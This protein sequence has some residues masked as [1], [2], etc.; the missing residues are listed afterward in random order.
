MSTFDP[1]RLEHVIIDE[2]MQMQRY[3]A[4]IAMEDILLSGGKRTERPDGMM[5]RY[6]KY[7]EER[8]AQEMAEEEAQEAN[9]A[10][11]SDFPLEV[12]FVGEVKLQA[13]YRIK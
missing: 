11:P 2:E 9:E 1:P 7:A 6:R 5:A 13:T 8:H 4:E 12:E 10:A 3:L